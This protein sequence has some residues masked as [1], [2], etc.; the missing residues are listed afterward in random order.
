MTPTRPVI[1]TAAFW[2]DVLERVLRA[3]AA[4]DLAII[5]VDHE[6][7]DWGNLGFTSGITALVTLLLCLAARPAGD[8]EIPSASFVLTSGRKAE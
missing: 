5:A 2:I 6:H 7:I 3:V 8:H 1:I 4:A